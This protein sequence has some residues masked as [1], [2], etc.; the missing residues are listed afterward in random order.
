MPVE[1]PNLPNHGIVVEGPTS[2]RNSLRDVFDKN[3][4]KRHHHQLKLKNAPAARRAKV[5][6]PNSKAPAPPPSLNKDLASSRT[7]NEIDQRLRDFLLSLPG[8]S[9]RGLGYV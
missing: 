8:A 5:I 3:D 9:I 2:F 6:V 7:P 1:V 4:S